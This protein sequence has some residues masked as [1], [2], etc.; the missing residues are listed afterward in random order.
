MRSPGSSS[1]TRD[2]SK[3]W[4]TWRASRR[5]AATPPG[6]DR[7]LART[8]EYATDDLVAPTRAARQRTRRRRSPATPAREHNARRSRRARRFSRRTDPEDIER[9]AAQFLTPDVPGDLAAYG[10]PAGRIRDERAWPVP[11][12]VSTTSIRRRS[13]TSTPT[14]RRGRSSSRRPGRRSTRA[15]IAQ[16]RMAVERWQPS[17]L[18]DPDQSMDAL[19]RS[20]DRTRCCGCTDSD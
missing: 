5:C 7:W 20:R 3:R 13:P 11:S 15:T 16:T 9:F 12:G 17:Y 8:R 4:C 14:S 18:H 10:A 19:A 2:T 6:V 1:S